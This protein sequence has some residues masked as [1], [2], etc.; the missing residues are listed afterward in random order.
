MRNI[1]LYISKIIFLIDKDLNNILLMSV[2]FVLSAFL[3]LIGLGFLFIFIQGVLNFENFIN[4]EFVQYIINFVPFIEFSK[5]NFFLSTG[6]IL[7]I[8]FLFKSLI[9]IFVQAKIIDYSLYRE[10]ILRNKL[11][12]YYINLN[13]LE[14]TKKNHTEYFQTLGGKVGQF[15]L[16]LMSLLRIFSDFIIALII[17][18]GLMYLDFLILFILVSSISLLLIFYFIYF[19]NKIEKY[20]EDINYGSNLM[21]KGLISIING[22]KEI[23]IL[24]VVSYIL[25]STTKGSEI[26]Y[27]AS[28]KDR[29]IQIAPRY[30]LEFIL[31]LFAIVVISIGLFFEKNEIELISL[32][33]VFAAASLRLAPMSNQILS[34]FSTIQFSKPSISDLYD[35]L[36]DINIST[37]K[38]TLTHNNN[39]IKTFNKLQ[40]INSFFRYSQQD[41]WVLKNVDIDINKGDFIG[42]IGESGSGKTT[43]VDILL[44]LLKI[45]NG[46]LIINGENFYSN[47]LNWQSMFAY[48]PQN[49]F[50]MNDSILKN[51]TF[52]DSITEVDEVKLK[53]SITKAQLNKH[54]SQLD[55]GINTII[56]DN[57]IRLSGGQR[58]RIAIARAFYF[59][60]EIFI[61]DEATNALDKETEHEI[62]KELKSLSEDKTIIMISHNIDSIKFFNH[63]YRISKNQIKKI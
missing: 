38:Q 11:L 54:I 57:G 59:E 2:Y 58:Q 29:L 50:L 43:L 36:Y 23:R 14:F 46:K 18:T 5:F 7:I 6:I 24:G 19:K 30:I 22:L 26:V 31:V 34:S 21:N 51:I 25:S 3:D 63:V 8:I 13:Y 55:K 12:N 33:G 32:L 15:G 4:Y 40:L 61:L 60:R 37:H 53:L 16:A 44:G 47:I 48:I 39:Q 42:I 41:P 45:S 27:R 35:E 49:I 17:I 28:Y 20:G 9:S 10:K 56:G 1:Y 62:L 52:K